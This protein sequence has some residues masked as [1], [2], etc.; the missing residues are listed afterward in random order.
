MFLPVGLTQRCLQ[1]AGP[2]PPVRLRLGGRLQHGAITLQVNGVNG[3]NGVGGG[4]EL[5]VQTGMLSVYVRVR[6]RHAH[7]CM[8]V[9]T[10]LRVG[11]GEGES[12]GVPA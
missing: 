5:A 9:C 3:V 1:G 2:E 4:E 8:L 6:G 7:A 11:D 12:L 10:G